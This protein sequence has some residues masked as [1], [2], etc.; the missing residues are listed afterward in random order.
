MFDGVVVHLH[1]LGVILFQP[2]VFLYAV[3]DEADGLLPLDL[4][5]CLALLPV[6][7]PCFRPPP[8][9]CPVG[10]YRNNPRYI[11]TL[12]VDVQFRQRVDGSA[13]DYGFVIKFFFTSLPIVERYT[14]CRRAR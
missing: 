7:E 6:I 2:C 11:E 3:M 8:D 10:I 13:A 9:A 1:L 14:S 5:R 4:H 12:Y